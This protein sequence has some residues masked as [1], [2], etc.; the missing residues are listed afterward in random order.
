MI[1]KKMSELYKSVISRHNTV[2][3]KKTPIDLNAVV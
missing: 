3:G 2:Q 1:S